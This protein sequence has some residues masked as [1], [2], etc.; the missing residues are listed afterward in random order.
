MSGV[1]VPLSKRRRTAV[2]VQDNTLTC[3]DENAT[4]PEAPRE[5]S[6]GVAVTTPADL[7]C[8]QSS[9]PDPSDESDLG[10]ERISDDSDDS[11]EDECREAVAAFDEGISRA[12]DKSTSKP[13]KRVKE[14]R[15]LLRLL[16]SKRWQDEHRNMFWD[17][18]E[19]RVFRLL[20]LSAQETVESSLDFV[21]EFLEQQLLKMKK[22][23][24][25]QHLL[26][27]S[28]VA[29]GC[30]NKIARLN[31]MK[32]LQLFVKKQPLKEAIFEKVK[33]KK[34]ISSELSQRL[35]DR[36]TSVRVLSVD[37]VC[38]FL[39]FFQ[40]MSEQLARLI[41]H[42]KVKV[43]RSI[44]F[45]MQPVI[46]TC[47]PCADL[48]TQWLVDRTR[49]E[50][51]LVRFMSL[52][53]LNDI[54]PPCSALQRAIIVLSLDDRD[55]K[56][57]ESALKLVEKWISE[58]G[59]ILQ[60]CEEFA[61]CESAVTVCINHAI[62]SQ[63]VNPISLNL[64][65]LSVDN[66]KLP[67]L[68]FL[69]KYLHK[70]IEDK[71]D[72]EEFVES[73][74]LTPIVA[75]DIIQVLS[76]QPVE[77]KHFLLLLLDLKFAPW[78]E[79][80]CEPLACSLCEVVCKEI[81][82]RDCRTLLVKLI[83]QLC[84]PQSAEQFLN[85]GL[86][87]II[88]EIEYPLEEPQDFFSESQE[89]VCTVEDISNFEEQYKLLCM[90][91]SNL[92]IASV[93][94]NKNNI[95]NF[96]QEH[97]A[98]TFDRGCGQIRVLLAT[99]AMLE[100]MPQDACDNVCE[101]YLDSLYSDLVKPHMDSEIECVKQAA[102]YCY[103]LYCM[104]K[105]DTVILE[106]FD[107]FIKLLS[108][109]QTVDF[110]VICLKF[111]F[112]FLL[113]SDSS[114]DQLGLP[115]TESTEA[116]LSV[117]LKYLV[118]VPTF[119]KSCHIPWMHH[120]LQF[121][122]FTDERQTI[123]VQGFCKLYLRAISHHS[124]LIDSV[125]VAKLW[126]LLWSRHLRDSPLEWLVHD[127]METFIKK[128][129]QQ[130]E[131]LQ[132]ELITKCENA[133]IMTLHALSLASDKSLIIPAVKEFLGLTT[134]M[135]ITVKVDA[136]EYQLT[137]HARLALAFLCEMKPPPSKEC[138][139]L[140][141]ILSQCFD[142]LIL[143]EKLSGDS[144]LRNA[145]ATLASLIHQEYPK[146][147]PVVKKLKL[148]TREIRKNRSNFEAL[149][150]D[151]RILYTLHQA[152]TSASKNV[153]GSSEFPNSVPASKVVHSRPRLSLNVSPVPFPDLP[154]ASINPDENRN[155]PSTDL[156][157]TFCKLAPEECGALTRI[158]EHLGSSVWKDKVF[159]RGITHVVTPEPSLWAL[160][161]LLTHKWVVSPQWLYEC[162][163]AGKFLPEDRFGRRLSQNPVKAKK[164]CLLGQFTSSSTFD[165]GNLGRVLTSCHAALVERLAEADIII[166]GE[167]NENEPP[168]Q[169]F[170]PP[171]PHTRTMTWF[172]FYNFVLSS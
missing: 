39:E 122:D 108:L 11:D 133:F 84:A 67:H 22:P 79:S 43:R 26:K 136:C 113:A 156:V 21:A 163:S 100:A 110:Q 9:S 120:L 143:A 170:P 73:L 128:S 101:P 130:L 14:A 20:T 138:S 33:L 40:G 34:K 152:D 117:P 30:N 123:T 144:I 59:N 169:D 83:S 160:L 171:S 129:F 99:Q 118:I 132:M 107:H 77:L 19:H 135:S 57:A 13:N 141:R 159:H 145:T 63:A 157:I 81:L 93:F 15:I 70:L 126:T 168:S 46:F 36:T 25:I 54:S 53:K 80:A 17:C 45:S 69:W 137:E 37:V 42:D 74:Q 115:E 29:A 105:G 49:D 47:Q 3:N 85:F 131:S 121:T 164:I 4:S 82:T 167:I 104:C 38:S 153:T 61:F 148:G 149:V 150:A 24:Y 6:H 89:K 51:E 146:A 78:Q 155:Q 62:S 95:H 96:L 75:M 56:V 60:V 66:A 44:V 87:H 90:A 5:S 86:E 124:Y 111:I 64:V 23:K 142:K 140:G 116:P 31:W 52:S 50:D 154:S 41:S 165:A 76:L 92:D 18:F 134:G 125:C 119:P 112:D 166:K 48:A 94:A 102:L 28:L 162:E 91:E 172:Q 65:P 97:K 158:A 12:L 139:F 8:Q 161:A 106:E 32:M 147:P 127:F 151:L 35:L 16:L 68:L 114:V 88:S 1:H 58:T 72:P 71:K 55:H 10:E 7:G 27:H 103:G 109:A 2:T 98:S